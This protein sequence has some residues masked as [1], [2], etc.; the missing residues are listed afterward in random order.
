MNSSL[1]FRSELVETLTNKCVV[2]GATFPLHKHP[3]LLIGNGGSAAVASHICND[4]IKNG[5][6]AYVPDYA[7]LMAL[8]NDDGWESALRN[9]LEATLPANGVVV[10]ISSSG[11]SLNIVRA[12]LYAHD[13]GQLITLT[14][15][16][17]DNPVRKLG[18]TNYWVDSRNYGVVEIC[19]LA[20]LHSLVNPG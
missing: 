5:G 11:R 9:W 16:D 18:H 13:R 10:A 3:V 19:H 12:C 4:L 1:A 2:D 17:H 7:T 20:I 8:A 6:H 15:F 14:G